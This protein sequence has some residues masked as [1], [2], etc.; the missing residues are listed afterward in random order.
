MSETSIR[1]IKIEDPSDGPRKTLRAAIY[2]RYS[3]IN[4]SP[5]SAAEQIER[6]RYRVD[7]K[8][9]HSSRFPGAEIVIIDRWVVKDEAVSGRIASREGY[10]LIKA[11]IQTKEFDVLLMDDIARMTRDMGDTIDLYNALTFRDI[12]GISISDNISTSMPNSRDLFIFKG[13][14]NEHLAA[15]TS[16]NTIRG[17]EVRALK[18]FSTGHNPYGYSSVATSVQVVKGIEKPSHFK[19]EI[20]HVQAAIVRD[21]WSWFA[22][23][24]GVHKI[25]EI[26]NERG[27][28]SPGKSGRWSEKTVWNI[29]HQDK[30]LGIWRY[31]QTMVVKNPDT[32]KMVQKERPPREWIVAERLDLRIIPSEIEQKVKARLEQTGAARSQAGTKE[33][34]IFGVDG[35]KPSHLFVGTMRCGVCGGNFILVGGKKGGYLG[36]WNNHRHTTETCTNKRTVQMRWVEHHLIEL[37]KRH[38]DSPETFKLMARFY[39]DI[40]RQRH[41][42]LPKRIAELE[43]EMHDLDKAIANYD[44]FIKSGNWS[45]VIARNL[46]TAE[47]QR[48]RVKAELDVIRPQAEDRLYITPQALQTRMADIQELLGQ[49]VADANRI[50]KK[51][52]PGQIEML[53]QPAESKAPYEAVGKIDLS[54]LVGFTLAVSGVP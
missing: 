8:Q 30:Y 48:K 52:F 50:L 21:I 40:M 11:A 36:C 46:A 24:D 6:I 19:I 44:R 34:R 45:D 28:P 42:G 32:S 13:Y 27:I 3:T 10:E 29:L 7:S 15:Q 41:G 1:I 43:A 49:K 25:A 14:A 51:M 38:L 47:T 26:L 33:T 23:G 31:R 53:P 20:N 35:G 39:N 17:L 16:K 5:L 2:A 18:G 22:D 12:E 9:I 37:L 4:N 54:G